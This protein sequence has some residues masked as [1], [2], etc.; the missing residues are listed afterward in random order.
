M[1]GIFSELSGALETL[2]NEEFTWDEDVNFLQ[3]FLRDPHLKAMT[4]VNDRVANSIGFENPVGA[5][6]RSFHEVSSFGV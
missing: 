3:S 6:E 5:A 1:L 4:E 2:R